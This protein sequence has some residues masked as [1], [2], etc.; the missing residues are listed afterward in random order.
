LEWRKKY[1]PEGKGVDG[2]EKPAAEKPAAA[3]PPPGAKKYRWDPVKK[4]RVE[5]TE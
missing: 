3:Q 4:Q 5:I 2:A 1:N